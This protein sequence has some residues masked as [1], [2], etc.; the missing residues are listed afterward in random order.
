MLSGCLMAY[1]CRLLVEIF[2]A[3]FFSDK[4][5][6]CLS[7]FAFIPHPHPQKPTTKSSRRGRGRHRCNNSRR[8]AHCSFPPQTIFGDCLRRIGACRAPF[9]F[10]CRNQPRKTGRPLSLGFIPPLCLPVSPCHIA[11]SA[12]NSIPIGIN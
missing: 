5:K 2:Y 8:L 10:S 1:M 7:F 9:F 4:Q 12:P 6:G 3:L 11:P